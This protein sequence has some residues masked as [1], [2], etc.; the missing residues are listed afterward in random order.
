MSAIVARTLTTA[1]FE[2]LRCLEVLHSQ[3]LG[4]SAYELKIAS[5]QTTPCN[6]TIS[7]SKNGA[8]LN[9]IDLSVGIMSFLRACGDGGASKSLPHFYR[10]R[11]YLF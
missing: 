3:D 6:F 9:P 1:Y 4:M 8:G 10:K 11:R 7:P 5:P 2:S